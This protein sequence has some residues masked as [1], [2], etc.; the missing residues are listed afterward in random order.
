MKK[1]YVSI[2]VAVAIVFGVAYQ[3]TT[4]IKNTHSS[5]G[6][7]GVT[8]SPGENTC[9]QSTCHGAGASGGLADNAGPG[10]VA[11]T[12]S[13]A[14]VNN[15]YEA[16]QTY[17]ITVT[18]NQVGCSYFGFDFEAL[19][20]SKPF[21]SLTTN[22]SIGTLSTDANFPDV[23]VA[24]YIGSK[25]NF[26]AFHNN[27]ITTTDKAVFTFN[28]KAPASG[29]VSM[30]AAGN[31]ANNNS[32]SDG[33]DNIY[34]TSLLNIT[35]AIV[36]GIENVD[37]QSGLKVYPNPVTDFV[38][39]A[40]DLK[41][42][43]EVS[44]AFMN[45]NGVVVKTITKKLTAGAVKTSLDLSTVEKGNYILVLNTSSAQALTKLIKK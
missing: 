36:T 24:Q 5:G 16:G 34:K 15:T 32:F 9:S 23:S 8:G 6:K 2:A 7:R 33:G 37:L 12:T 11:I 14:L 26:N 3:A 18:V 44:F 30:Y 25:G 45:S 17:S 10:S 31:A 22:N 20:A 41:A 27:P 29:T 13:P 43:E 39:V 1:T 35:P 21:T 38:T 42:D 40:F 19:D 28:W 4:A